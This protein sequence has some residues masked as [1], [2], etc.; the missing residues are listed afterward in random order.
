MGVGI[1][2]FVLV[3]MDC[4]LLSLDRAI[5]HHS[6]VFEESGVRIRTMCGACTHYVLLYYY[7]KIKSKIRFKIL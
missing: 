6:R 1:L 5:Q 3:Y 2:T 7:N 4:Y